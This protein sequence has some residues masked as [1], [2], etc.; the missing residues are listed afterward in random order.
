M[1]NLYLSSLVFIC[2]FV[3]NSGYTS[4]L[5]AGTSIAIDIPEQYNI[6]QG[7]IIGSVESISCGPNIVTQFKQEVESSID[8]NAIPIINIKFSNNGENREYEL[9]VS[10]AASKSTEKILDITKCNTQIKKMSS[11]ALNIDNI[12]IQNDS[13][14]FNGIHNN[15]PCILELTG[16]N[17]YKPNIVL[18]FMNYK[19]NLTRIV[20][21]NLNNFTIK[22]SSN[23][24]LTNVIAESKSKKY[25]LDYM[26]CEKGGSF[27]T[28][29]DYYHVELG[30]CNL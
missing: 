28:E 27:N 21:N 10:D 4:A 25:A 12:D 26:M 17:N 9:S 2:T 13:I 16:S 1:K 8:K 14:V 6:T 11:D 29:S 24:T 19:C 23:Y 30:F 3:F 7:E 22:C 20:S 15:K 18:D 5:I